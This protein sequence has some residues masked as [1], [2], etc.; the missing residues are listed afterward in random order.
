MERNE[1]R[2]KNWKSFGDVLQI[3]QEEENELVSL[4]QEV[5]DEEE[6]DVYNVEDEEEQ[7]CIPLIH[8]CYKGETEVSYVLYVCV[9]VCDRESLGWGCNMC[10]IIVQTSL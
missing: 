6:L 10:E 2:Q 9:C 3:E 7:G 8:A 5:E 1:N 4:G